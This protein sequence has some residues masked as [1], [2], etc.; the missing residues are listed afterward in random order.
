MDTRFIKKSLSA[1]GPLF[2]L[3]FVFGLFAVIS[4][5]AFTSFYN[6]KTILTQSVIIAIAALGMT[7]VIIARGIDLSVGSQI[8]LATVVVAIVLRGSGDSMGFA[9][10]LLAALAGIAACGA[11]GM[12]SGLVVT[13][14]RIVPFI[15]TLGSLSL[16]SGLAL[17][18][19]TGVPIYGMP[20]LERPYLPL[21]I[22]V[23]E[24]RARMHIAQ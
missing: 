13:R 20:A 7:F 1:L 6:I 10:P 3:L 24:K 21:G 22:F 2:G 11:V 14:F 19:T 23:A 9:L 12:L 4:P 15:V 5:S 8:A 18:I 17:Y 16:T